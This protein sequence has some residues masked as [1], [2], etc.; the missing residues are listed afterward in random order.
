[1]PVDKKIFGKKFIQMPEDTIKEK[2]LSNGAYRILSYLATKP[3]NWEPN[4]TDI[5]NNVPQSKDSVRKHMTEL[6]KLG[7]AKSVQARSQ[8]N[9][10]IGK[11]IW[12][13]ALFPSFDGCV[14]RFLDFEI[15]NTKF[16]PEDKVRKQKTLKTY[17]ELV[18]KD[19]LTNCET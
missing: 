19:V 14:S 10:R 5:A 18:K 8:K 3:A 13:I 16:T 7:Y 9:G 6:V 1:M 4:V 12:F 17:F 2:N 15:K 11:K